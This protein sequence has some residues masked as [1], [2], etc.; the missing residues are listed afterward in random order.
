MDKTMAFRLTIFAALLIAV[1]VL[2]QQPRTTIKPSSPDDQDGLG[3]DSQVQPGVPRGEIFKL[4]FDH[5]KILPGTSRTT[6]VY[7]PMQYKGDKPPCVYVGLD[8]LGFEAPI[9]FDNL[10]HKKEMPITIGIGISSGRVE[11][12]KPPGNPG[13]NRSFEVDGLND[14]LAL[15][16]SVRENATQ[17]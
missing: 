17:R 10:I 16:E 7:V 5:S 1:G 2:A 15:N 6:T 4:T 3:S 9:V 14:N 13:F 12:A 11:S 8:S